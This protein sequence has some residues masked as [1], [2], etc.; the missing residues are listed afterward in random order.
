MNFLAPLFLLG[1]L[2]VALP[3]LFHLIRRSVKD[4]TIFSSLLFLMPSPPRLTR[5]SRLEHLLLLALR[6]AVLCLLAA[7]FARPFLKQAGFPA[8]PTEPAKR[9][10]LLL[11]SSASMRREGLW[12]AAQARVEEIVRKA[13]HADEVALFTFDRQL[14]PLIPFDLWNETAVGDRLALVRNGLADT[15]PGWASTALDS[16]LTEAAELFGDRSKD[17]FAGQKQIVVVSDFQEGSRLAALQGYQ[18]PGGVQIIQ[19]GIVPRSANNASLLAV[20]DMPGSA[21]T[22]EAALRVRVSNAAG[23][24]VDQFRVGWANSSEAFVGNPVDVYVP[25]GQSRTVSIPVVATNPASERILLTGD[26]E[27][28]D[29]TVWIIPPE[30]SQ[31]TVVYLGDDLETDAR[32]PLFFLRRALQDTPRQLFRI[33]APG[34]SAPISLARGGGESLFVVTSSVSETQATQLREALSLGASLLVVPITA[35]AAA[36][37]G[38]IL[39]VNLPPA[40]EQKLAGYA[41]LTDLRFSHPLFTPFADPRFSDFTK[42]HFWN[43]RQMDFSALTNAQILARFDTGDPAVVSIPAGK[44]QVWVLTSGWHPA[45]SQLGLSSKFVPLLYSM[46]ELGGAALS[47]PAQ[48]FVG[49]RLPVGSIASDPQAQPKIQLPHGSEVTL[50]P[51]ERDFAASEPG[52]YSVVSAGSTSRFAVNLEPSESRT[53]PLPGGELERLGVPGKEPGPLARNNTENKVRLQNAELEARQKIWRWIIVAALVMLGL[54]T[55]LAGWIA[56]RSVL[57]EEAT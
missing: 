5:R 39:Q 30:R 16:A 56:R 6:C 42:I 38:K 11:D 52:I 40:K 46:V 26:A 29:N 3:V 32:Q 47:L 31:V 35:E 28:F 36:G 20:A 2:A 18:W 51:G 55:W 8:G 24:R 1:A 27:P 44:S 9:V 49:A 41:M 19:E 50:M 14:K 21:A 13:G 33:V 10:I 45:D 15:H 22:T 4:R 43:Y 7:G 12:S 57:R 23:S 53:A 54:E 17:D 37:L 25:A 48:H 34:T